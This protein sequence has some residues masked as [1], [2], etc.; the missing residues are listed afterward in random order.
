MKLPDN[1]RQR[2][3]G[4]RWMK[5][6]SEFPA[7][8][9]TGPRQSV[10]TTMLRHLCGPERRYVTLDDLGR[11]DLARSD[12]GLFLQQYPPPVLIDEIQYAPDLL[13][14]IKMSID[15]ERRPGAFWMTGSQHFHLMQGI[16]ETLAGRVALLK[17]LGLSRR[18]TR[19]A[20]LDLPPFLPTPERLRA[21][22]PGQPAAG[23]DE[24]YRWIWQGS[25]PELATGQV[26]DRDVFYSSYLQTYVQRD[27]RD[28]ARVGDLLVF[29]RFV[30]ACAARTG[31]VLNLS[32]LARDTDVSVPTAKAW[33]SI[34]EAGFLV[35]LLC[36]LASNVTRRLIKA[37]KIYFLDTG[38]CAWLTEWSTP[39]TLA[40]GAMAG[41]IL[42]THSVAEILKS[43]WHRGREPA[44]YY[45]RDRDG[46]EIDLVFASDGHLHPF[47]IK[48]GATPRRK[49]SGTFRAL[50]R[51]E[52]PRGHGAVLCLAPEITPLDE[53]A[54]AV[55]VD[56]V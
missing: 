13:P 23:L 45:Y 7:L 42:E 30:R 1:Y 39:E 2:A 48:R 37:P 34:L 52:Y 46:R 54:N 12:P 18:E 25:L 6:S 3:L 43:W 8:L 33:L 4:N 15:E 32:D 31:Q 22:A 51:L 26:S 9:L 27:V 40:A 11:R 5:M 17:M 47:E 21:L 38:L 53:L 16:G 41:A 10:K 35:F 14:Y 36:P 44:L 50:D 28:L 49:W 56:V 20:D 24:I 55:P 19:G 29:T